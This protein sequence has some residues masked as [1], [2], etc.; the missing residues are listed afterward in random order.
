M[1]VPAGDVC[2]SSDRACGR[3]GCG[4]DNLMDSSCDP[5]G[6]PMGE[7]DLM[8]WVRSLIVVVL[9]AERELLMGSAALLSDRPDACEALAVWELPG[10]VEIVCPE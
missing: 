1:R 7:E 5:L 2:E 6:C 4:S 9:V 3:A 8:A 10:R